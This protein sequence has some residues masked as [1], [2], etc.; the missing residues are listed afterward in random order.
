MS[1]VGKTPIS[2]PEGVEVKIENNIISAK[3]KLG[4]LSQELN[5]LVNVAINDN[6]EIQVQPVSKNRDARS[7]WGTM[8]RLIS[9]IVLGVSAGF[10]KKLVIEG[11][12]YRASVAGTTLKVQVGKS[13]DEDIPIPTGLSVKCPKPTE[14]EISGASKK[15][16][17]DFA[18][19]VRSRRTPE[20]YKGKGI[21][22]SDEIIV[23]KEGKKK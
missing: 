15:T 22:Y 8:Q 4:E 2:I 9:N 16:V 7:M 19:D 3:G 17:G 12:G 5:S 11:V 20:P 6:K 13:H 18:A 14:I 23:R 10:E 21:R 1:R